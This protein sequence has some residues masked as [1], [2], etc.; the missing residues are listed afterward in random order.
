MYFCGTIRACLV[1]IVGIVFS[2]EVAA[3][4][5]PV[6]SEKKLVTL[7]QRIQQGTNPLEAKLNFLVSDRTLT[8]SFGVDL[9]Q[10]TLASHLQKILPTEDQLV[11]IDTL[12]SW[13]FQN[14]GVRPFQYYPTRAQK[15][16]L[17]DAF[18]VIGIF[19]KIRILKGIHESQG[20]NENSP[21]PLPANIP[22]VKD[23]SGCVR[24]AS[25]KD[26]TSV[27]R[28]TTFRVHYPGFKE[29]AMLAQFEASD[30]QPRKKCSAV[31]I[32]SG[33]ALTARHCFDDAGKD[34]QFFL[35]LGP[36]KVGVSIDSLS[37]CQK[38]PYDACPFNV[39]RLDRPK[40][41]EEKNEKS[42]LDSAK[43]IATAD[44]ALLP[45]AKNQVLPDGWRFAKLQAVAKLGK[46]E[47]GE[48]KSRWLTMVGFGW[49]SVAARHELSGGYWL[50]PVEIPTFP[51][52]L[53]LLDNTLLYQTRL[54]NY[55]SGGPVFVGPYTG[56]ESYDQP[57]VL[58][59][60]MQGGNYN[61][62]KE[63]CAK[64]PKSLLQ[65]LTPEVVTWICEQSNEI[66]GC[67]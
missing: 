3:Q 8:R 32:G 58:S 43:F 54:C 42:P 5:C 59:A 28:G 1:T 30:T 4:P 37:G 53:A 27:G 11:P 2:V 22:H 40:F 15:Q 36:P 34:V 25:L 56:G 51:G 20:F 7:E 14:V 64:S 9:G 12:L 35:L 26:M 46:T 41:P 33:Y 52:G 55:D 13:Q 31:I 21:T 23:E 16:D 17:D 29:V 6:K 50:S 48:D 63:V 49:S 39:L 65:L 10:P 47:N 67:K 66:E 19:E 24:P 38:Q 18:R 61:G 44:V 45:F 60:L 62:N 57:R